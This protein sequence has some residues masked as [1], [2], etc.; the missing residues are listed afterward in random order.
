[1]WTREQEQAINAR[2]GTLLVSAAAGS[3]KTAVLVERVIGWL[4]DENT[5]CGAENLL[6]VTFSREATAQIRGRIAAALAARLAKEPGNCGLLRQ[7]RLLPFAKICTID[8][9]CNDIIKENFHELDISPDYRI[10]DET[11]LSILKNE[12]A[13]QVAESL[14][15]E[16]APE[17]R[18]LVEL[19]FKGRDDTALT[20]TIFSLDD[21]AGAYPFPEQWL[22]S[23]C[24]PFEKDEPLSESGFGRLVLEHVRES[25]EFCVEASENMC[26]RAK[27][28]PEICAAYVPTF[29]S[30]IVLY[31]GMLDALGGCWDETAAAVHRAGK[32]FERIGSLPRGY[33]SPL[34]DSLQDRRGKLKDIVQKK[35]PK[36]FCVTE[37][38]NR[39]DMAYCRPI[40]RKLVSAVLMYRRTLLAMKK[41]AS[42]Y[43][44][45]DVSSFALS[46][47]IKRGDDG[48]TRKTKLAESLSERFFEILVDEFQ[49]INE[50]QEL[51][52]KALSRDGQ[53]LFMVG[54]VK[55]SIY[56]FRQAMPEIFLRIRAG[57][58]KYEDG[59]YPASISLDR[60]FRSRKGVT[61]TVN[62]IFNQI[63]SEKSGEIDYRS[64][65]ALVA[66]ADYEER[67]TPDAEVHLL[68]LSRAEGDKI[69]LEAAYIADVIKDMLDGGLT[70][71]DG[72]SVR[73]AAFGDFCILR[74]SRKNQEAFTRELT[75]RG[76]P[77]YAETDGGFFDAAE[78]S[79]M[80]AL[81]KFL[82]N[83]VQDIPLTAVMLSPAFGFS[84]DD[85]A[86]LRI[87]DR[88]SN[89]YTCLLN[90]AQS[91]DENSQKYA[92]FLSEIRTYRRLSATLTAGELVRRLMDETGYLAVAGA[93]TNGR[94]RRAN[95]LRFQALAAQYESFGGGGL[96]GFVRFIDRMDK[97]RSKL[98]G[99]NQPRAGVDAVRVMTIHKSKGL[100]FPVCILANC[101]GKYNEDEIRAKYVIHQRHGIGLT[102]RD[103]ERRVEYRTLSKEAVSLAFTKSM[104]GEEMRLLYVAMTRA[105]EKLVMV[106]PHADPQK[107]LAGL[108]ANAYGETLSPFAVGNMKC[109]GDL[110]MTA[111]LR[112]PD[113]HVFRELA[114]ADGSAVLPAE[115]RLK[116]IFGEPRPFAG[117]EAAAKEQCESDDTILRELDERL[118]Y[119]YP[120]EALSGV[121]AKHS[122]S[123]MEELTLN[124]EFFAARLPAFM[125]EKSLTPA[126]RG[127]AAHKF[128]QHSDYHRA[129]A[130]VKAEIERLVSSGRLTR[131]EGSAIDK[132]SLERFFASGIA[133]RMLA[134]ER[135]LREKRFA[136]VKRAGEV[137]PDLP[138]NAA[139]EEVVIQGMV[140]C[141][142]IEDGGLVI[143]DYK[144]DRAALAELRER[145]AEQLNVYRGA[146]EEYTGLPVRE[147]LIYSFYNND[148]A[149]L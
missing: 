68:D 9:F 30:D 14:Y 58:P 72:E 128:M 101:S 93:M 144:T 48:S 6:I 25:L 76:V 95:L 142:F 146:M 10:L 4:T 77:V 50:A 123:K 38:Q 45:A 85:L 82:D 21:K 74:R 114:G 141:A 44:F 97:S 66:A 71:K 147:V 31:K 104:S 47:L 99:G 15:E 84:P 67:P 24:A 138:P 64:G 16:N 143:I 12:A 26:E 148:A 96:P 83:P 131:T 36:C 129:A 134:S 120:Y 108:A 87:R 51:L 39:E 107:Y 133:A 125:S 91:D 22:N 20:D 106:V 27:A 145:Y 109:F 53:N 115:F 5:G 127:T 11:E 59:N 149:A 17:F 69:A 130:D 29:T 90:A 3:G 37:E 79:F 34:K 139:A 110:I 57:L 33:A 54:D 46:L 126:Q 117:E 41:E 52:F 137:Y 23:L 2:K 98:G 80:V 28:E 102:R 88:H 63:M 105:K 75:R 100:E 121:M 7:Q 92:D 60:N 56:R 43:H 32:Q 113:A 19:L 132:K 35:L 81:L 124:R 65:E 78:I 122:A 49:D 73:A 86:A 103:P 62:Y 89:L 55:Q 140:D 116:A 70:V 40:V 8:S 94:C 135:I 42:A 61:E 1:M 119:V 18:E 111:A 118:L 112:H 13:S 136:I